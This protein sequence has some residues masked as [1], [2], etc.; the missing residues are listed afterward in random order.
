MSLRSKAF[1]A[2]GAIRPPDLANEL[3]GVVYTGFTSVVVHN[4]VD[5]TAPVLLAGGAGPQTI[6]SN[7][8]IFSD[9]GI[10]VE[11]VGVGKGSVLI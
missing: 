7:T 4:G 8:S 5:A 3:W 1:T 2:S 9:L 6:I 10:Y 11:V